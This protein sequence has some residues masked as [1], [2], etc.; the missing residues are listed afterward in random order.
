M[1]DGRGTWDADR[2]A[3]VIGNLVSNA[4]QHSPRT[5]ALRL[6]TR[7]EPDDVVIEVHNE[8]EPIPADALDRLFQ[9]FERG[10]G[11]VPSSERSVGLGLFISKEV[12]LAHHGTIAVRSTE[13]DGTAFIVR[14]PRHAMGSS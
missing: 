5:A 11:T 4:F 2:I 9:P 3:Q 10:A 14:L 13:P 8:G 6:H 1:G 7:G 12:V